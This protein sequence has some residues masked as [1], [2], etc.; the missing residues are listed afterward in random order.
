[1]SYNDTP[2]D[3][4]IFFKILARYDVK[5]G[6]SID[7]I[8]SILESKNWIIQLKNNYPEY[9]E[10][11]NNFD[12]QWYE[13]MHMELKKLQEEETIVYTQA[14]KINIQKPDLKQSFDILNDS[15][16]ISN[17]S[18]WGKISDAILNIKNTTGILFNEIKNIDY[19]LLI[20]DIYIQ[21][22]NSNF[23]DSPI[24]MFWFV[25][26]YIIGFILA[27]GKPE[28]NDE[29]KIKQLSEVNKSNTTVL[30]DIIH[31]EK[32]TTNNLDKMKVVNKELLDTE[33]ITPIPKIHNKH[34]INKNDKSER[35]DVYEKSIKN[36]DLEQKKQK[37][38]LV[39][40]TLLILVLFTLILGAVFMF[41]KIQ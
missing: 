19:F 40:V 36:L 22:S 15:S 34:F 31:R 12:E 26:L 13:M 33:N 30:T 39:K 7:K 1:M 3:N 5:T 41:Y 32:E 8:N 2:T 17:N 24:L 37:T 38:I 28:V 35:S 23:I 14:S 11:K 27:M 18:L 9:F 25:I 10:I 16:L 6:Y 29:K 20:K 21:K 4:T